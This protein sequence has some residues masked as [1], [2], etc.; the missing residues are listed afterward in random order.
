MKVTMFILVFPNYIIGWFWWDAQGQRQ[1]GMDF[2]QHGLQN[3]WGEYG[4]HKGYFVMSDAWFD[5]YVLQIVTNESFTSKKLTDIWKS[6]DYKVLPYYD[7]MGA[8]A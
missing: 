3:I 5:E 2:L 6:K 7:P 8:L 4:Q 1:N